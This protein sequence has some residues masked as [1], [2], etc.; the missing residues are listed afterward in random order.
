[1]KILPSIIAAAV[2]SGLVVILNSKTLLPAPLGKLLSPQHG[3][4]QNAENDEN[5]FSAQLKFP[6][7]TG[8]VDVY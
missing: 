2:T 6:Q 4:W 1:M 8:K 5:D 3:I 7:L